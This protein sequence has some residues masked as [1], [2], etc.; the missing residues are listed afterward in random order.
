MAED[1]R[2]SRSAPSDDGID[3]ILTELS[4]AGREATFGFDAIG[5]LSKGAMPEHCP[6]CLSTKL[7]LAIDHQQQWNY[8]CRE[9][10]M[11]WHSEFGELRRVDR[12]TC[13]GCDLA[14]TA[15]F[16]RFEQPTVLTA[17]H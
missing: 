10:T 15:C 6:N 13:P 5:G 12:E 1:F 14:T 11:C 16:E 2:I 17:R 8:F 3:D 4:Q 7:L 9:C